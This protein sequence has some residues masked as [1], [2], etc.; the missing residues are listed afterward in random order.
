M[1]GRLDEAAGS[2]TIG[3]KKQVILLLA[4]QKNSVDR[5]RRLWSFRFVLGRRKDRHGDAKGNVGGW[6]VIR[7]Y[8]ACFASHLP[9]S[10]VLRS[11]CP[12]LYVRR[13]MI[14]NNL[15]D[16]GAEVTGSSGLGCAA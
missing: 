4:P 8:S 6:D 2:T 7:I 11:N 9:P 12:G 5:C 10:V 16:F 15:A 13:R 1:G 14:W 3:E